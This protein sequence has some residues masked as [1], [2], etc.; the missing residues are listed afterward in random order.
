M[1]GVLALATV[2]MAGTP[3]A[4]SS[5]IVT[6]AT[7][8][9]AAPGWGPSVVGSVGAF[10]FNGNYSLL[11]GGAFAGASYTWDQKADVNSVGIYAGPSSQLINGVTTTTI[12]TM[13]YLNLYQ[14][15]SAGGFGVGF[16]TRFWQSGLT[17][18]KAISAS[19]TYLALGYQF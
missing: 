19:T 2:A 1:V 16:G 14:T 8:T 7:A 6:T 9:P 3:A 18:G 12:N 15:A 10:Y 17:M 5:T 11:N 4:T 13:L